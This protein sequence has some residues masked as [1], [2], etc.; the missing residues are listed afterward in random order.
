MSSEEI[1]FGRKQ[2]MI[3]PNPLSFLIL[4]HSLISNLHV[5]VADVMLF[6]N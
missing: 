5:A 2:N 3:A 6:P 1:R 4:D